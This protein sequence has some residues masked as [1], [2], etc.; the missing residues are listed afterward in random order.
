MNEG[1]I[2]HFNIRVYGLIL[3]EKNQILLSDEYVLDQ[4]MTK[5]PGG[6]LQFGEGPADCIKREAL[7][8]F[9]QEIEILEHFY[10][11]HFF[12][13]AMFYPDHQLISIYYRIRFSE[14][15]RFKISTTPYD[16][17][18]K[19]NGSQSFRWA[20]IDMLKE[21]E[22]SFPVDRYVLGLLK[23]QTP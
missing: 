21:E 16:F 7:E 9:G 13:K 6:G 2:K 17:P 15:I 1:A 19:I 22:L 18:E 5:F 10:T 20:D 8:E 4:R 11:T 3:D 14:P 12:Q 23:N